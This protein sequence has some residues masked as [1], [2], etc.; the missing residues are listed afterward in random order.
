[1]NSRSYITPVS[2]LFRLRNPEECSAWGRF[3]ELY[4]P[5]L[6]HWARQLGCQESDAADL[7]QDV[8]VILWQKMPEFEYDSSRSFHA[9]LKTI[10]LNRFRSLGRRKVPISMQSGSGLSDGNSEIELD[11]TEDLQFLMRRA[12][13][14]IESEFSE[15]HR[16]VFQMYVFDQLAPDKVAQAT[17]IS[18]GT[19]YSIKSKILSRLKLELKQIVE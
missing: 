14:I 10:F 8:F 13:V 17:G 16:N 7:V 3:V 15:L 4:T 9:W 1:M 2:L 18:V 12:F 11:D 6:F 5:L 19:V